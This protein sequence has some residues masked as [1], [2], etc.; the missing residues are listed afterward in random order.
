[1]NILPE[2]FS[3]DWRAFL[4]KGAEIPSTKGIYKLKDIKPTP[5][6]GYMSQRIIV[7]VLDENGFPIPGVEVAFNYSTGKPIILRGDWKWSPLIGSITGDVVTT[8]GS[9]EVEHIQGSAVKEGEAG[10]VT[11]WIKDPE[12][13][14]DIVSGLGMLAD[15]TGVYMTYQRKDRGVLGFEERLEKIETL[16]A[17]MDYLRPTKV[18]YKNADE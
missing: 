3:R 16:I 18:T 5:G 13:N 17:K 12:R 9:G 4:H 15:H 14:C 10:G 8:R 1:M 11:V 7:L 2:I 6:G